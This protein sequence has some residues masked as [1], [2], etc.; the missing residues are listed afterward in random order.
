MSAYC[1][2]HLIT[3]SFIT[4][5]ITLQAI[6]RKTSPAPMGQ[7]PLFLSN[8]IKRHDREISIV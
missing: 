2:L 5:T 3:S 8:G 1:L 4:E 7:S 6:L